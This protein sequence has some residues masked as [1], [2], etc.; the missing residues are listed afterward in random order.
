MAHGWAIGDFVMGHRGIRKTDCLVQK[1][2]F[3]VISIRELTEI[4]DFDALIFFFGDQGKNRSSRGED[5]VL[6]WRSEQ[7]LLSQRLKPFFFFKNLGRNSSP[8]GE[9]LLFNYFFFEI[10][11]ITGQAKLTR[12]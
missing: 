2:L 5:F 10:R 3:S 4:G 6:F 8:R 7:K 1:S 9:D 11:E 12:K